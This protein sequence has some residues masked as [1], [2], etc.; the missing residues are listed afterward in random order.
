MF[1]SKLLALLEITV[2]RFIRYYL[3]GVT[4]AGI[5]AGAIR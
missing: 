1:V 3:S 4:G 5:E 2:H